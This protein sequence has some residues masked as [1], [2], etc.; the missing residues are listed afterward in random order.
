M[1]KRNNKELCKFIDNVKENLTELKNEEKSKADELDSKLYGNDL[2][3]ML[4]R[5]NESYFKGLIRGMEIVQERLKV[6]E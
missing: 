2:K 1:I 5:K 6:K 4:H 3:Y